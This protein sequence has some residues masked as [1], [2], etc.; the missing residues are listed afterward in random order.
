MAC[1]DAVPLQTLTTQ[2][3]GTSANASIVVDAFKE[4]GLDADYRASL[5]PAATKMSS[6][7]G[8]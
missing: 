7:L 1:D 3:I 5:R 6:K 2:F 4:A 8:S